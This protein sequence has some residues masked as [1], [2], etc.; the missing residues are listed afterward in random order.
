MTVGII[1]L[2]IMGGAY[3][4]NLIKAGETVIGVDPAATA[5]QKIAEAGGVVHDQPGPW[6]ADCDVVILSLLSPAILASVTSALGKLVSPGQLVLETGTF[7]L[8]DKETARQ[9]LAKADAILL[10]CP[11]SGTGAQA[12][13]G[14]LV[15]M[16]SGPHEAVEQARPIA[17]KFTNLV[18][19]AGT[20]GDGTK[21]KFVAN[22]AVALHNAAA[23]ETLHFAD[24]L[25]LDRAL[26]FEMLSS[27]GGQSRMSDLRMPL[28][29]SGTYTP[30][31]ASL[32][33][34]AKDF[35]VIGDS[36]TEHDAQA[37]L[38]DAARKLYDQA[39]ATLPDDY[40]TAA[41]FEVYRQAK[42]GKD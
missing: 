2:G 22:H 27:G 20:F 11:V 26:V 38:F 9:E 41:V 32:K 15:M 6:I 29:M 7:A 30:P 19:N 37:P 40:D 28:M 39:F 23:A 13:T 24:Q 33:M 10:D 4:R 42:A 5:R 17:S 36:L 31:T 14:D 3:A 35:A 1:G 34:F 25:D 18:I 16:A 12:V 21:L 8:A